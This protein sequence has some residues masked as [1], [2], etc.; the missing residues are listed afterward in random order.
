M[1]VL[2]NTSEDST[3]HNWTKNKPLSTFLFFIF[4]QNPGFWSI[5]K[6][7]HNELFNLPFPKKKLSF[8]LI[9]FV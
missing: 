2:K 7:L 8:Y 9:I 1:H 3:Q 4:L 6:D 5:V